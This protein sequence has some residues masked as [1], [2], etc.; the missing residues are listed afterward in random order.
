MRTYGY[1]DPV[2]VPNKDVRWTPGKVIALALAL[3]FLVGVWYALNQKLLLGSNWISET[4]D[5]EDWRTNEG[6]LH[7]FGAWDLEAHIWKTEYMREHFPNHNWNPY[8]YLGMPLFKYYQNAFYFVHWGVILATGL[9]TARAALLLIVGAHLLATLLTFLLCYKI[10]RR[11]WVSALC[12]SFLLTNTFLS[13]RSYGWE[14]ITVVFL[15]LYPLGLLLF[16]KDP[17]RPLRF[18][19]IIVLGIAYLSHPLLWFSLCMT[20]GLYLFLIAVQNKKNEAAKNRHYI[21]SYVLLVLLS[22]MVG[23]VQFLPQFAYEQVTSGAHM[24][25]TYLPFYQVEFNIITL[26]DFFF[27][28]GNLKGPGPIIMIATALV[29]AF[30]L[31]QSADRK[32]PRVLKHD[33]VTGFAFVLFFMVLFYYIELFNLFP[34]NVLRSIQYHRIIPEFIVTAAVLIAALSHVTKGTF[35]KA[36]YYT[37]LVAFVLASFIVVYNVQEHWQTT[38]TIEQKSEF[39]HEEFEGRFSVPYTDQSFAVRNSFTNQHQTYGYYEQGIT[40]AYDDEIFS[41][42]SGYH[43]RDLTLIYLKAANV[44]RLY[45]NT[46]EGER[47]RIVRLRLNDTLELRH[48]NERYSYFEIPLA[49]PE[50]AQAVPAQGVREVAALELGCREMFEEEYCGSRKEEFV[51]TDD[52][53]V[54]YLSAYVELLEQEYAPRARIEMRDPDH[55]TIRVEDAQEETMVVVKMTYDEDFLAQVGG[56]EIPITRIGPDYMLLAPGQQGTYEIELEYEIASSIRIGAIASIS[57]I[58]LLA[59]F[60]LVRRFVRLKKPSFMQFRKGDM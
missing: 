11:V 57:V 8:W 2:L 32:G 38:P 55:Y 58:A 30:A 52:A 37:M 40:N 5:N 46:Q 9:N 41:V 39:V 7:T 29:F 10:S 42:S 60:F 25:V 48:F 15:F 34:M 23:A 36:T 53:E 56:R 59:V 47:D 26:K 4:Y 33:I 54:A 49:H 27:D 51:S 43:P 24:G 16:L 1:T 18:W 3:L 6:N 22:L 28:M 12:S 45:V 31:F 35:Q 21:W 50:L 17:L 13:L 20:M 14:P 19:L 44:A